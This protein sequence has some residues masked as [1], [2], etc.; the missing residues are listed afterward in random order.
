MLVGVLQPRNWAAK[1]VGRV[2][3][4]VLVGVVVTECL[5]QPAAVEVVH[6]EEVVL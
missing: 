6:P 1:V 4:E 3:E 5:M 2:I